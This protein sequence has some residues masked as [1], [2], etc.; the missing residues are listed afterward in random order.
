MPPH[1]GD[2]AG[3]GWAARGIGRLDL[4]GREASINYLLTADA[5][6]LPVTCVGRGSGREATGINRAPGA[7][8]Y[9]PAAAWPGPPAAGLDA[10]S[11]QVS[12]KG[13]RHSPSGLRADA[14]S[15]GPRCAGRCARHRKDTRAGSLSSPARVPR[16][17]CA[18]VCRAPRGP[19]VWRPWGTG[20]GR[21]RGHRG[22]SQESS[23]LGRASLL[24]PSGP[25]RRAPWGG[26]PGSRPGRAC[27]GP[28]GDSGGERPQPGGCTSRPFT[29]GSRA[30]CAGARRGERGEG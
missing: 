27:P 23:G 5:I 17:G 1:G 20:R 10:R 21:L 28:T 14:P 15:R 6:R 12:Q 3:G 22:T 7:G 29:A 9:R 26:A 19:A 2:A 13:D 18:C 8:C 11:S 30:G 25:G 16:M 4:A 24:R